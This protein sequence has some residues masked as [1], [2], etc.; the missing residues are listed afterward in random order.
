MTRSTGWRNVLL[1][2]ATGYFGAHILAEL[3]RCDT[4]MVTCHLRGGG[5]ERVEAALRQNGLWQDG[6]A[7][8]FTAVTGDLEQPKLG[9][10]AAFDRLASRIDCVIH[11][12]AN[13]NYVLGLKQL[14][15]ANVTATQD[16]LRLAEA[17]GAP[18][19][20]VSTLR[21]FDHRTD[22]T[23]IREDD[24]VDPEQAMQYGY[25]NSKMLS[26]RLVAAAARRGL[27]AAI[28]RPGLMCGDGTVGAPNPRDAVTLLIR[29]CAAL[30][31]APDSPLQINSTSVAYGARGLVAL[32]AD[33]RQHP[34]GT[35][36]HLVHDKPSRMTDVFTLMQARGWPLRLVP[37]E[38]WV[39]RLRAAP[40]SD[41]APLAG[42]FTPEF[43][44]QS[45]RRLFDSRRTREALAALGIT[46][47]EPDAAF[48]HAN[49]E[50]MRARGVIPDLAP[51]PEM[52]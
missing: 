52:T 42:Y 41:L 8:R 1:T 10:G 6:F 9:L 48:W 37:Y 7:G 15:A 19:L 2:G 20:F 12:G 22:G 11:N 45:T 17:T 25:A 4:A 36:W 47:P 5:A 35:I 14:R 40:D 3:L 24:P 16:A 49:L 51:I 31:V 30:G 29:A 26:E 21:L 44:L 50:G 39:A 43:P 32:G 18:F 34:P 23:P 13:V 38:D 33:I 28:F 27:P 46:H